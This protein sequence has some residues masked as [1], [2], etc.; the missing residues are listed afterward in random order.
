MI[1]DLTGKPYEAGNLSSELD[2][3]VKS[4]VADFCGKDEYELG[5]LSWEID[6]RVKNRVGE[7]TGKEDYEFGDI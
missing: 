1:E 5:D 2:R 3:R 4:A 6:N 7:F